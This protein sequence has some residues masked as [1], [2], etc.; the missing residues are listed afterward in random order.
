[1]NSARQF[2]ENQLVN[3]KQAAEYL[4]VSESYL[5][6]L[7][8]RGAISYVSLGSRGVRFRVESLNR[9]INEREVL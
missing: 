3:Y 8:A 6:K 7:K 5:R 2:F 9:W 4:C 1:M